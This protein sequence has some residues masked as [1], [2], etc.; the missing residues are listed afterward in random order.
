MLYFDQYQIYKI[1]NNSD[2]S[3]PVKECNKTYHLTVCVT[4]NS[5]VLQNHCSPTESVTSGIAPSTTKSNECEDR[6]TPEHTLFTPATVTV[7]PTQTPDPS[8][9][10][11]LCSQN[12]DSDSD[13]KLKCSDR[14]SVQAM[15]VV[16]GLL[17]ALLV[18]MSAGYIYICW[19]MKKRGELRIISKQMTR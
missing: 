7:C 2:C 1:R 15:G 9:T 4:G 5:V 6:S 12:T 13:R 14:V 19:N 8:P 18:V 3:E 10:T 11:V 17:V 16:V